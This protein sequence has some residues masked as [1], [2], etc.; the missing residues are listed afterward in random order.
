MAT[1]RESL[2]EY[3]RRVDEV[4]GGAMTDRF[5]WKRLRSSILPVEPEALATCMTVDPVSR[6]Y[7]ELRVDSLIEDA[8]LTVRQRVLAEVA[9]AIAPL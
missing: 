5:H 7:T 8:E 2:A 3:L 6:R 4:V 1:L 9:A